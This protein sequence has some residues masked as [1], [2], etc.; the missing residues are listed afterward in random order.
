LATEKV[1][2]LPVPNIECIQI[3]SLP[4]LAKDWLFSCIIEMH[5]LFID[6]Y[7]LMHVKQ[8]FTVKI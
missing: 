7:N 5:S 1:Q 4:A 6:K 8:R 2:D 3:C